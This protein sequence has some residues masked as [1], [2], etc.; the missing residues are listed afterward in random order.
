A[1]DEHEHAAQDGKIAFAA[2]G[3][4][5]EYIFVDRQLG[6]GRHG[7][8]GFVEEGDIDRA[9]R[10]GFDDIAREQLGAVNDGFDGTVGAGHGDGAGDFAR[11]AHGAFV[12]G[13]HG[14]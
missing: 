5:I 12:A 3:G 13:G 1:A 4:R 10:V 2:A 7:E 9:L 6:V 14:L 11:D 8:T